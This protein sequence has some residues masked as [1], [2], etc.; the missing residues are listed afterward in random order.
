MC[1]FQ[2]WRQKTP[3]RTLLPRM[4]CG[5]HCQVRFNL[6]FRFT[7]N[8]NDFHCYK[9]QRVYIYSIYVDFKDIIMLLFCVSGRCR[10]KLIS[11]PNLGNTSV[12]IFTEDRQHIHVFINLHFKCILRLNFGVFQNQKHNCSPVLN[13]FKI[14]FCFF[15]SSRLMRPARRSS[16]WL[17]FVQSVMKNQI[18]SFAS[19]IKANSHLCLFGNKMFF[20]MFTRA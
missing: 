12:K 2:P 17:W 15:F 20:T 10:S 6:R 3:I 14:K 9:E 7:S 11:L 16:N 13:G 1:F 18:Q 4:H 5:Y 19:I 8:N